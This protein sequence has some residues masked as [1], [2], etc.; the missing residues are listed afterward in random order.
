V[1]GVKTK[2]D[3]ARRMNPSS[4]KPDHADDRLMTPLE[5]AAILNTSPTTLM[6]WRKGK[7]DPPLPYLQLGPRIYRYRFMD[8][9]NLLEKSA[10]QRAEI[11]A[12]KPNR[13]C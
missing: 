5:V 6:R 7:S 3:K 11:H 10:K 12:E 4:S 2:E 9:I 13:R 1:S 8:V